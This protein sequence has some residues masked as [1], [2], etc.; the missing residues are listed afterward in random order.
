MQEFR[1]GKKDILIERLQEALVK[2]NMTQED[3]CNLL[4]NDLYER[5]KIAYQIANARESSPSN[6]FNCKHLQIIEM[7]TNKLELD[8]NLVLLDSLMEH[9]RYF[10]RLTQSVRD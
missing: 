4:N 2:S 5:E 1:N 7:E 3:V 8:R 6:R 9:L 10:K